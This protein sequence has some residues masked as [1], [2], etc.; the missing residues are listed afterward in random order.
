MLIYDFR[1]SS[2]QLFLQSRALDRLVRFVILAS[3]FNPSACVT[4]TPKKSH[5]SLLFL[6][7][8]F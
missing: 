8:P 1:Q 7:G 3:S 5:T 2:Q 4:G 6:L